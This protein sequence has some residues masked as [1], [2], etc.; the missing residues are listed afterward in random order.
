MANLIQIDVEGVK[1]RIIGIDLG[2]TNSLV[3]HMV[4][5]NPEVIKDDKGKV[6]L[7]SIITVFDDEHIVVGEEAKHL[8]LKETSKTVYSVKRLMG[9][10]YQDVTD[11]LTFLTYHL[12][13]KTEGL[14]RIEINGKEYTPIELSS[15][16]LKS[17]KK[18]A[19]E[20]FND[21]IKQ[22]VITVPAYFNDAQRQ[23]T[24]DAGKLA[25]LDV[26]RI[27]NE[28]TAA[29]LAYG[30]DKKKEGIIAVYDL[31]GGTFDISILKVKNGIFEVL[32]TNGNT[33]LGGDDIDRKLME[34]IL[35][36]IKEIYPDAVPSP[37]DIQIIRDYAE[38]I[39]CGLSSTDKYIVDMELPD[40]GIMY[41]RNFLI[42]D[43]EIL[44]KE[45]ID[46]TIDPCEKAIKDAG[47]KPEEIEVVV[48][49]G[50]STRMPLVKRTVEQVFKKKPFDDLNPDE[51]VALGAAIQADILAG[52][53]KD[54]L[55]LDV[56]PLSLGIETFGG[57]M[58][59]IIPRNTTIPTKVTEAFT[60]FVDNQ[61]GVDIHVLQG[62]RELA[63]DNRSLAKFT[64]KGIP[65]MKAGLP[66][67]EV[68]FM[69]NADGILRVSAKELRT[70]LE[71]KVEVKPSY[72]LTD[73]EIEQ[74]LMESI[75]YAEYD[76]KARM[77]IESKNEAN[78]L[79]KS[80]ENVLA[81]NRDSFS[82]EEINSVM[83]IMQTLRD[84]LQHDELTIIRS[85]TKELDNLTRPIA[86]RVMNETIQ[87]A[88]S[89][90]NVDEI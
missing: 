64:L 19:E 29:A 84:T 86:Q 51:V 3:A 58:S 74:M 45:I 20:F 22:A 62:E 46:K 35:K 60:T 76:I 54:L 56:T 78:A 90:K 6:L 23:A 57:V 63:T 85:L 7:P 73:E 53:R 18:R 55:L 9:K 70:N 77:L 36:E 13:P 61:T 25:G 38:K 52:S 67:V 68:T 28:P 75:Q 50:G 2:T 79:L 88:L 5:G 21:E 48:L 30:L 32:S 27:V 1:K 24:K 43:F 83:N 37:S 71:Q 66:K 87:G 12:L 81:A 26:L 69:V 11:D 16:I 41:S 65:P 31:G 72:G 89:T 80:I 39:K 8:L 59:V 40:S 33:R 15:M 10:S 14:V 82:N 17:L 47:L 49:V 44:V 42:E 4:Q 34:F